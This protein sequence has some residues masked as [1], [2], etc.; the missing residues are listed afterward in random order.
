MKGSEYKHLLC[1]VKDHDCLSANDLLGYCKIDWK[2]CLE[3]N[4][5][6]Y[7]VIKKSFP[8]KGS[9]ALVKKFPDLV[10]GEVYV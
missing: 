8:L 7:W 2:V 4:N 5:S 1:K 3:K 10:F 6:G 9:P